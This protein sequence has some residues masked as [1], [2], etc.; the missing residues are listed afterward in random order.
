MEGS[1]GLVVENKIFDPKEIF[2][3]GWI[4]VGPK[5]IGDVRSGGIK[6]GSNLFLVDL[7]LGV[8]IFFEIFFFMFGGKK[9]FSGGQDE[10]K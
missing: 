4:G 2:W 6:W 8:N 3:I 5:A 10:K 7:V 9:N 1:F